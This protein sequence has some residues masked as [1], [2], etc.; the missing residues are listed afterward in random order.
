MLPLFLQWTHLL[1]L[2]PDGEAKLDTLGIV[3]DSWADM[4]IKGKKVR[5]DFAK[6]ENQTGTLGKVLSV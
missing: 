5:P 1:P 3:L 4:D 2:G 6:R